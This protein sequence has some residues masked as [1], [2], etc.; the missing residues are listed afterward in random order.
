MGATFLVEFQ[1]R[2]KTKT[3]AP[4]FFFFFF[5]DLSWNVEEM[6]APPCETRRGKEEK[7]KTE[8]EQKCS[9]TWRLLWR[10]HQHVFLFFFPYFLCVCRRSAH[11]IHFH[12]DLCGVRC[13]LHGRGS[14][15]LSV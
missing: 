13:Q 1:C 4:F 15:S 6:G 2:F 5:A 11:F 9:E 3:T 12:Y 14:L 10:F 8:K 7:R